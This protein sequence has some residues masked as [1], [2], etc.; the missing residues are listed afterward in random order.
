MLPAVFHTR[1]SASVTPVVA[2]L[3]E[4]SFDV[5]SWAGGFMLTADWSP[6][7]VYTL[8]L[9]FDSS[10]G[11]RKMVIYA[12]NKGKNNCTYLL[13]DTLVLGAAATVLLAVLVKEPLNVQIS[14]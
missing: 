14:S 12:V 11:W 13:A 2:V 10:S 9:L 8:A 4:V 6:R 5:K 1:S 7:P 3:C